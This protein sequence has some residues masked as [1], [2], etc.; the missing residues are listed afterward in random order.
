MTVFIIKFCLRAKTISMSLQRLHQEGL[1]AKVQKRHFTMAEFPQKHARSKQYKQETKKAFVS[2]AGYYRRFIPA[3]AE[4]TAG[5]TD[6]MRATAPNSPRAADSIHLTQGG[7]QP[8]TYIA[9]PRLQQ[10]VLYL[11]ADAS[12]RGIGAVLNTMGPVPYFSR[13]LLPRM[14]Q[15]TLK[16]F[17]PYLLG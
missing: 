13:K 4:L 17:S 3:F 7:T 16:H 10:P 5:L 6:T 15:L 11:Q 1:Q 12:E 14:L 9:E 2:L 8:R